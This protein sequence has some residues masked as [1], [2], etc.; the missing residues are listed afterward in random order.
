M[1]K[2]KFLTQFPVDHLLFPVMFCLILF[3]LSFAILAYISKIVSY[4]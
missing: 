2:S 4:L 3:L 1:L